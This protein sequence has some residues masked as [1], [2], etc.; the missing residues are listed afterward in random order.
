MSE[1]TPVRVVLVTAPDSESGASIARKLVQE[2]L[3]ACVNLLPAV[4]SIYRWEGRVED[5]GEVL[6]VIKTSA[7]RCDAVAGRVKDLHPYELPEVIALP[8]VGGSP[9]YLD[10]VVRESEERG[11]RAG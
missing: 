3:V 10:W 7:A 8:V 4:R 2:R 6:L 11:E 1:A 5:D 9:G